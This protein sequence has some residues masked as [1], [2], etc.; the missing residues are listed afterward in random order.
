M[1]KVLSVNPLRCTGCRICELVCSMK[2]CG[3]YNPMKSRIRVYL[4]PKDACAV[5]LT[6][7]QCED[8]WCERICPTGAITTTEDKAGIKKVEID[9]DR[10]TGCKMCLLACPFGNIG[11]S[12]AGYAVKCDLC[13]GD[14]ECV[15]FCYSKALQFEEPEAERMYKGKTISEKILSLYRDLRD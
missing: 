4:F 13:D 14:P 12:E 5:P 10:C 1:G 7:F 2:H 6:C 15:K 8:A 3:E 9:K 11:F